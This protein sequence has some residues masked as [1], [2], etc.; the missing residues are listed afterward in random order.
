[1]SRLGREAGFEHLIPPNYRRLVTARA[2]GYAGW[3]DLLAAPHAEVILRY[4]VH[5][6]ED[7]ARKRKTPQG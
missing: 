7:E 5:M 4:D 3:D 1:M 2:L 6:A